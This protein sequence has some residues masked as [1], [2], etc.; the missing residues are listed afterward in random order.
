MNK[1]PGIMIPPTV[2]ISTIIDTATPSSSTDSENRVVGESSIFIGQLQH[3]P[4]RRRPV[5]AM[6]SLPWVAYQAPREEGT[7]DEDAAV[8]S[9][10]F[11]ST[12][13]GIGFG[14][15]MPGGSVSSLALSPPGLSPLNFND[16][17]PFSLAS[18]PSSTSSLIR[19]QNRFTFD[20]IP[21]V[22]SST[23]STPA[24][25]STGPPGLSPGGLARTIE[26]ERSAF[27]V[28]SSH[29][30]SAEEIL[31][32]VRLGT[33]GSSSS[34]N[35]RNSQSEVILETEP[36]TSIATADGSVPGQYYCFICEKDFRRP[37]ILSRHTRRHTG[38]KPFKCED[39]G[40]FFSRSDHL[41]THRRTHTDEKPYHCCVCNYS[42]RRRDVLTRHMSTR[43]Q[44]VAPP[45]SL[46]THRNVRRCLSDGDYHKMAAQELR[47]RHQ[48]NRED[49]EVPPMEDIEDDVIVDD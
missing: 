44:A 35:T 8:E 6:A 27:E 33:S 46:G 13:P 39:C 37:D 3:P 5:S 23:N 19:N 48:T 17:S 42:A 49:V 28:V 43:H 38:E 20:H 12:S 11:L 25:A 10:L 4:L 30:Q 9:T 18:T 24:T 7:D 40:R 36:S 47:E 41:R 45:S 34:N 32:R 16:G 1:R 26:H 22:G 29:H 2:E 15:P 14:S 21:F 31:Q